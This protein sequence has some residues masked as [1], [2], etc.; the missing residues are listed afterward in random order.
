[1]QKNRWKIIGHQLLTASAIELCMIRMTSCSSV[2][3]QP[4][5]CVLRNEIKKGTQR[6][7]TNY[8]EINNEGR[9]QCTL[10]HWQ[11]REPQ[12]NEVLLCPP[13]KEVIKRN[14]HLSEVFFS[15]LFLKSTAHSR[16]TSNRLPK[17]SFFH[18][19]HWIELP[20][21][22]KPPCMTST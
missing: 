3:T 11:M 1:M 10:L 14:T 4:W 5:L 21:S 19:S 15:I 2:P 9:N 8:D 6:H 16:C 17:C 12:K 7:W 18:M 20:F 13:S 22:T